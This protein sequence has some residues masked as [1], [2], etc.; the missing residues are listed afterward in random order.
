MA[1]MGFELLFL[2]IFLRHLQ[3]GSIHILLCMEK[4]CIILK[5]R[6]EVLKV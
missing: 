3:F 5:T 4:R 2:V 6:T 1:E